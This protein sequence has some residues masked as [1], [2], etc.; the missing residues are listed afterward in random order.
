MLG[1]RDL[2]G[3]FQPEA[4]YVSM[5]VEIRSREYSLYVFFNQRIKLINFL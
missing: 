2:T 1:L 4:F 3:L 5:K